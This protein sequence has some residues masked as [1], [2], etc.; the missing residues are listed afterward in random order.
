MRPAQANNS[1]RSLPF[2]TTLGS[3]A[4]SFALFIATLVL[5]AHVLH[6][7]RLSFESFFTDPRVSLISVLEQCVSK[8]FVGQQKAERSRTSEQANKRERNRS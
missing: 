6:N 1:S 3:L 7:P 5:F 4:R 8:E 2:T